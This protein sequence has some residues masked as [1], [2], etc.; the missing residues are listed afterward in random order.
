[1]A[2]HSAVI[3]MGTDCP[4]LDAQLLQAAAHH[5]CHADTV[6]YP[7]SDGGYALLGLRRSHERLFEDIEWSTNSVFKST[8]GR[9]AELG[10]SVHVGP[11]LHDVDEPADLVHL[12]ENWR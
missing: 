4:S 11:T 6:L 12:P 2:Q 8:L 9:I 7:A 10:W 3:F 5:L 1:L